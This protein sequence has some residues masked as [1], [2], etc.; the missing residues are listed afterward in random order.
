MLSNE[1]DLF[2][3]SH[4]AGSAVALQILNILEEQG[5]FVVKQYFAGASIPPSEPVKENMWRGVSDNMLKSVLEKAGASF[6]TLSHQHI[7]DM[8]V[9]FRRDT[10][11]WTTYFSTPHCK[12]HCPVSLILARKDLFTPN[13]QDAVPLWHRYVQSVKTLDYMDT[14]SH[15]FQSEKA[16]DLIKI[17]ARITSGKN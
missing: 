7:T 2:L 16:N 5:K 11:F 17:I 8:L 1:E 14:D 6:D 13:N 10:D 4:C 15:Y 12:I 9:R 3:Y